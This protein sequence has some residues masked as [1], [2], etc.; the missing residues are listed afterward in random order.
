MTDEQIQE[1]ASGAAA[2]I[3]VRIEKMAN[4]IFGLKPDAIDP[5]VQENL[6]RNLTDIISGHIRKAINP[7]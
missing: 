2:E 6:K 3:A 7:K 4:G 5:E 1:A